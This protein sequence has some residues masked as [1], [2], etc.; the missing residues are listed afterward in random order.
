MSTSKKTRQKSHDAEMDLPEQSRMRLK[1]RD[2]D[3]L[4]LESAQ[5]RWRA[6]E[7]GEQEYIELA[8]AAMMR[9][10][11]P[12]TD[13]EEREDRARVL[14]YICHSSPVM[15]TRLGLDPFEDGD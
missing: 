15:R 6:G 5:Q 11:D 1:S 8:I 3:L 2:P 7:I 4:A 14:R 13:S 12:V 10:L 9:Q